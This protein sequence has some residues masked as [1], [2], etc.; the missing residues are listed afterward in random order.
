M[1]Y[2]Q[3]EWLNVVARKDVFV[4]FSLQNCKCVIGNPALGNLTHA[5]D[6][7]LQ[8]ILDKLDVYTV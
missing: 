6:V 7:L 1:A 8:K 2:E 4:A 3:R 5:S